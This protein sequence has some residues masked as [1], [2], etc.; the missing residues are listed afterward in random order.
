MA[1]GNESALRHHGPYPESAPDS[2]DMRTH[3]TK[4]SVKMQTRWIPYAVTSQC[5]IKINDAIFSGWHTAFNCGACEWSGGLYEGKIDEQTLKFN[6][7]DAH[8]SPC[9]SHIL[10]TFT[11]TFHSEWSQFFFYTRQAFF[12]GRGLHFLSLPYSGILIMGVRLTSHWT[13]AAFT[14]LL[15]VLRWVKGWMKELFFQFSEKWSQRW[16]D[17]DRGKPKNSEKNLSQC[18][19]VHHKSHWI[20]LGTNPDRRGENPA[21]NHLSHGMA[22]R[23]ANFPIFIRTQRSNFITE[24]NDYYCFLRITLSVLSSL[25]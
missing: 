3:I 15:S 22:C 2:D 13:A 6:S 10:H 17:I 20:D 1:S 4:S 8:I 5:W 19:L 7:Y 21:T 11:R 24:C 25:K 16:K 14:G 12:G 23:S 18:H 9:S